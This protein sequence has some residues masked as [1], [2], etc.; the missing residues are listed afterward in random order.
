M[1]ANTPIQVCPAC[2]KEY[3]GFPA[4]SRKDNATSICTPCG[5]DEAL[6]EYY[7]QD[8]RTRGR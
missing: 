7:A 6:E 2:K 3:T 4:L 1:T 8:A 5:E